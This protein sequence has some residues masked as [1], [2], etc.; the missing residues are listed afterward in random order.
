MQSVFV[1]KLKESFLGFASETFLDGNS[2]C[3]GEGLELLALGVN[4][5]QY[6]GMV[7]WVN[8]AVQES[9]THGISAGTDDKITPHDISLKTGCL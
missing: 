2:S 8:V 4:N 1:P 6:E 7:D 9:G 3:L 5:T